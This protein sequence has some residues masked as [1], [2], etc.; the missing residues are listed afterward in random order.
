MG[1]PSY[2]LSLKQI[3]TLFIFFGTQKNYGQVKVKLKRGRINFSCKQ[4]RCIQEG[5][6]ERFF[7][8]GS[9]NQKRR[10]YGQ[11]I[12]KKHEKMTDNGSKN[13]FRAQD[14]GNF[15]LRMGSPSYP[16]SLKQISI[17]FIFFGTQKNYGQVK[18]KFFFVRQV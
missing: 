10:S 7:I 5:Y 13:D 15:I 16:P 12:G 17:L 18:V 2:I 1:S 6:R 3:G 9:Q 11:K 4:K 14:Q 8:W